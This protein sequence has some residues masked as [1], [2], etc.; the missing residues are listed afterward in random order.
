MPQAA[1]CPIRCF[2]KKKGENMLFELNQKEPELFSG[3]L[4]VYFIRE[5]K[6]SAV[7]CSSKA[8]RKALKRAWKSGDFTGNKGQTF[9]FYPSASSKK[10]AARRVLAV[11]L[12]KK[13]DTS[14]NNALR[15]QL[16]SAA[17][18]AV[19]QA[20]GLKVKSMMF[21]PPETTGLADTEVAECLTEGLILGSYRFD[22][23]KSTQES[24][25]ERTEIETF[26]LQV[27]R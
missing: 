16:R 23:Y 2:A 21:V 8:V 27:G 5:S 4:L 13:E 22:K 26:S 7:P 18:T 11:G 25:D 6:G 19:Q 10:L 1:G 15:E 14:D 17:G 20:T 9:L 12:D 24:E 3:D